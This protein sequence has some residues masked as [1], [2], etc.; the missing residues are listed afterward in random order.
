[1]ARED[2]LGGTMKKL[3][4]LQKYLLGLGTLMALI[5][6]V[7][8]AEASNFGLSLNYS[9]GYGRQAYYPGNSMFGYGAA[10][11]S[12]GAINGC[13]GHAGGGGFNNGGGFGLAGARYP[14]YPG[15]IG[16]PQLSRPNIAP[17]PPLIPPHAG[18]GPIFGQ[19]GGGF[20]GGGLHGGGGSGGFIA[21]PSPSGCQTI[22]GGGYAPAAYG[23]APYTG[24]VAGGPSLQGGGYYQQGGNRTVASANLNSGYSVLGGGGTTIIDMRSRKAWEVEDTADIMWSTALGL[25]MTT[26][27]VFPFTG[28]RNGYTNLNLLYNTGDRDTLLQARPHAAQ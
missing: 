22:C 14:G 7:Q 10:A 8:T 18:G 1:M 2:F 5:A 26:T 27:N 13:F 20:L 21:S 24:A 15:P 3:N 12:L 6:T 23:P 17:F 16:V 4:T 25:G 11:N 28:P 9:N 19:T